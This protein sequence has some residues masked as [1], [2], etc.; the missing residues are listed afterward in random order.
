LSFTVYHEREASIGGLRPRFNTRYCDPAL[1]NMRHHWSTEILLV[2]SD[3]VQL[4]RIG[5]LIQLVSFKF[6]K[7]RSN[8]TESNLDSGIVADRILSL[9]FVNFETTSL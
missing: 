8:L 4:G 7:L 5:V 6:R 3:I 2:S 1:S 9:K